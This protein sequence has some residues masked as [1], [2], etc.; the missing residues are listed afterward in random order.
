MSYDASKPADNQYIAQGPAD[1][2][3][4]AEGLRT[5]RIVDAGMV[6]GLSPGNASGDIPVSNGN[7]N[8]NLNAE[9]IGGKHATD[10]AAANHIHN[11]ATQSSDGF[12]SMTD[13]QK[14]D[15]IAA[16]AQVNQNAFG[17]VLAN[18]T[19]VQSTSQTATIEI[20]AGTNIAVT[21][22]NTNKRVTIAVSGKVASAAAA[23]SATTAGTCT[24]NAATA[25]KLATA[26]TIATSGDATGTATSFDGSANIAIPLTLAASGVTAGT[27]SSVT[28]DAKG[29]VTAGT[30]PATI[31]ASTTGNAAT[32]TKLQTARTING[33]AFDG[34]ANITVTQ[35]N[36]KT[37]ATTDQIPASTYI[38]DESLGTNGYRKWSDGFI[39]QWGSI[40]SGA[41]GSAADQITY[42]AVGM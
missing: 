20:A 34:S 35:V 18:G 26:R 22:D 15:N 19:T 40:G 9:M 1:I 21:G 33:V 39:E 32:A 37:I 42:T 5:G 7:Q 2:R 24:G 16:G 29:R 25:T 41:A 12:M 31:S 14:L 11:D 38:V 3:N 28:V 27:Y 30:N 17:N 10:F 36:G 23:D 13:K 8:A 6:Q 4:N